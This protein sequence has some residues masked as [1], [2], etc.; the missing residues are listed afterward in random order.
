[1][2]AVAIFGFLLKLPVSHRCLFVTATHGADGAGYQLDVKAAR[3]ACTSTLRGTG[4]QSAAAA[5][6]A[7]ATVARSSAFQN[8]AGSGACS[9]EAAGTSAGWEHG[10]GNIQVHV[11][12]VCMGCA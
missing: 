9:A 12:L 6:V 7:A 1:M 10:Y 5:A 11:Q 2:L 8:S 4:G 3:P